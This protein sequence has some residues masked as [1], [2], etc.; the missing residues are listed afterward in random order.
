M[1]SQGHPLSPEHEY[2]INGVRVDISSCIIPK[3]MDSTLKM[4]LTGRQ[5]G[6]TCCLLARQYLEIVDK[7]F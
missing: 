6:T 4:S 3:A 7:C 5:L 2:V 1:G